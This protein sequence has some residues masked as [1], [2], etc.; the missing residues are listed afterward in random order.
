MW[1]TPV[2]LFLTPG[3]PLL[4]GAPGHPPTLTYDWLITLGIAVPLLYIQWENRR[5][6]LKVIK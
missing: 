6:L 3:Y 1:V 5:M 4:R 2:I